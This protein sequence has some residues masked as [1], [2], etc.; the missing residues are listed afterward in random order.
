[1]H[2][3]LILASNVILLSGLAACGLTTSG[4][5]DSTID[6]S[7]NTG[8][9]TSFESGGG[10]MSV[11]PEGTGGIDQCPQFTTEP[12]STRV[13]LTDYV[14]QSISEGKGG[15]L[16]DTPSTFKLVAVRMYGGDPKAKAE[17]DRAIRFV[18]EHHVEHFYFGEPTVARV[19]ELLSENQI[20]FSGRCG[21]TTGFQD[22]EYTFDG[23]RLHLIDRRS[24][25]VEVEDIY[26][27]TE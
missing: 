24:D 12:P 15:R 2:R 9:G 14:E 22:F 21:E 25:G 16:P 6:P 4:S 20:R 1:M 13:V 5:D 18:S 3:T 26:E 8:G 11:R 27:L 17:F 10:E 23:K 19:W 7:G